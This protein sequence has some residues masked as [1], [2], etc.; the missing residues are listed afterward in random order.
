[1]SKVKKAF[2]I[3][4]S[5]ILAFIVSVCVSGFI[6]NQGKVSGVIQN[7]GASLPVLYVRTG[8]CLM[9]EMHGY[10]EAVDAGYYRD[11]LTPVGDSQTINL[12]LNE[13]DYAIVS[14]SYELYNDRYDTL[15]ESGECTGMEKVNAMLQMQVV[16]SGKL[17]SNREY[18]L[19]LMMTDE[20]GQVFNYYTRVRYGSDLKAAEKLKFV[21]DFNEAT[22]DKDSASQLEPYLETSSSAGKSNFSVVT[23]YSSSDAVTWG[24]MAPYRT[25]EVAV[26]LKEINTETAAFTLTYT[27]ES[28]QG[29]INTFYNVEEYY[30]IR[31]T[32]TKIYLLDFERRMQEDI[33]LT[34][35]SVEDGAFRIG[36]GDTSDIS[37]GNYGTE[38]QSYTYVVVNNQLWLFDST[39]RILTKVYAE[40]DERHNCSREDELGIRVIHADPATGDLHFIVYGYMHDGNYEGREGVMICR[41]SHEDVMLE[42]LAFIPFDKGFQQLESGLEQLAYMNDSGQIY[43]L[44]EGKVYCID[45]SL[46]RVETA[47]TG[48]NSSNC[49]ASKTGILVLTDGGSDYGGEKLRMIDL[50]TG[51]EKKIE[52]GKWLITPLGFAGDDLIYGLIDPQL[53]AEDSSG[54]VQTP[55]SEVHIVDTDL[56]EIKSYQKAGSYVMRLT[57]SEGNIA[58]KLGKT[59]KNGGYTDYEDAGEDYIIRNSEAD[60]ST[61]YLETRKDSIRGVQNWLKLDTSNSF[62][63][64]TQTARYLDPGYDITKEYESSDSAE[65]CYYVYTKG[66]LDGTFSTIR[67]AID[68]GRTYAGTVMTSHKQV[69]WQKAG[70]AYIWDLNIDAIG[71][72]DGTNSLNQ[73]ILE[74]ITDFEGWEMPSAID[75]GQPLFQAMTDSLPAETIDLTGVELDD[76][77]HF[78]YRDRLVAARISDNMYALII[79]YDNNYIQLADPEEG[80]TYW[81][82]VSAAESL[83]E[84]NGNVFYSYID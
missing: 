56:N 61:V 14:G 80:D 25:S 47:W 63:P 34:D 42:E 33:S 43:L 19:R 71:H 6:M 30:R 32:S 72:A 1:M 60:S 16:F 78:I 52:G 39:N 5:Y 46:G 40:S 66:R 10:R 68:Y 51:K 13:Y 23:L 48:L 79:A 12:C 35:L 17:Y 18:C 7:T 62:V 41:F 24:S 27:I 50:N 69:L 22:F 9:N 4:F 8:G 15:I 81:L 82:T 77:L 75:A 2:L 57:V 49:S 74:A 36:I 84:E 59:V 58:L 76:V 37:V 64:I 31:W 44:L 28:S 65:L 45:A 29:D 20:D 11:T 26:R 21:L 38:E 67:E 55:I 73:V 83:F 3:V 54:V 70:R 53:V